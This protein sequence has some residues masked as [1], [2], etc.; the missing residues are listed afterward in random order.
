M[1]RLV[2]EHSLRSHAESFG[3]LME[4]K[5]AYSRIQRGEAIAE[6]K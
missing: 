3:T 1:L 2:L 6:W 4:L 5:R